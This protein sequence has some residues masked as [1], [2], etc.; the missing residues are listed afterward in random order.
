MLYISYGSQ[1]GNAESISKILHDE[2]Q[3]QGID[4]RLVT[5]NELI[6]NLESTQNDIL[7]VICSTYGN[8]D[9]PENAAKFWRKIK[10]RRLEKGFFKNL[11]YCVV[12]LGDTNYSH[13]CEMGKKIDTRICE[14][15][16]KRL[17]PLHP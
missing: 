16:G 9:A 6:D 15:G 7:I 10:Q 1:N 5:L 3:T 4:N 11:S 12:G 2:L 8:G 13:F 14:L 17:Y